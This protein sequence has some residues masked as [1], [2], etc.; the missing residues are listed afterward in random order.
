MNY[1]CKIA[2]LDEMEQKWEEEIAKHPHSRSNWTVWMAQAISSAKSG[3]SIP[4]YGILQGR[5]ICEAT[6]ILCPD[7]AQNSAG[8]I[9]RRTAYLCAFRTAEAYRGQGYFSKLLD[10]LLNDL[11]LR[12]Y[13]RATLGVEPDEEKNRQIYRHFGFT[14][15]IKEG[16]ETYPDGTKIPV[17]YYGKAL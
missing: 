13:A 16:W 11:R 14:E 15:W 9:D 17:F 1:I 4:Y 8:L 2:S 6:A 7:H 10:F 3:A 12:G 5:I